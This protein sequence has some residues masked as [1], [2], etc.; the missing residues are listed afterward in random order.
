[1]PASVSSASPG[2]RSSALRN[3]SF[4]RLG[5][6]AAVILAVV[7]L[8]QATKLLAAASLTPGVPV[9]VLGRFFMLTLIYNVGGALGTNIGSSNWYLVSSSIIL[10]FV[11]YYLAANRQRYI[12]SIPLALIAGGAIGNLIDRIRI[13]R[14]IDFLDFDFLDIH[15]LG[16]HMDRWWA[17]NVADAA[18]TSGIV[19]LLLVIL[20]LT[21]HQKKESL[22]HPGRSQFFPNS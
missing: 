2:K 18:I 12:V 21:P 14:V 13:G 4:T 1:M 3:S 7:I 11:L 17:F 8:D 10:I 20:F 19:L 5:W 22:Y 9:E 15:L 16:F 6:P